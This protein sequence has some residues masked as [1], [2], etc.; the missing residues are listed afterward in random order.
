MGT[1]QVGGGRLNRLGRVVL[2]AKNTARKSARGPVDGLLGPLAATTLL[3]GVLLLWAR[4]YEQSCVALASPGLVYFAVFWGLLQ[5]RLER[6]RFAIEYYLDG[7]SPWRRRLRRSW[8]SAVICIIAAL[9][10]AVFLA[11]FAALGR[12]TDWLFFTGAA[13]LAPLLFN[14]VSVWPGRHFRGA[15][16]GGVLAAPAGVLTSRVAGHVLLALVVI[17]FV[18]FN[19]STIP[20]P[21]I[22]YPDFPELTVEA[23]VVRVGSDCAVVEE[24]LR[25][26]AAFDGAGWFFM[27]SAERWMTEEIM[28]IFWAAFFLSAALA[29]TGFVRGLEGAML[30]TGCVEPRARAD[31]ARD[32]GAETSTSRWAGRIRRVTLLLVPLTVLT[33]VAHHVLQQRAVERWSAELRTDDRT[34][35]RRVIEVSVDNA[36]APAYA[37]IPEFADRHVS[38]GGFL[39]QIG[40]VFGEDRSPAAELSRMVGSAREVAVKDVHRT[41]REND[42]ARLAH[43]FNRDVAALPPG[44]RSA[45]EWV[46]EPVLGRA[47][48]GL[49]KAVGTDPSGVLGEMQRAAKTADIVTR[50]WNRLGWIVASGVGSDL[51]GKALRQWATEVL[52]QE[53][54]LARDD[55]WRAIETATRGNTHGARR[56]PVQAR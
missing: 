45:Y 28:L 48:S 6:R 56:S 3:L 36:F 2:Q 7:N 53:R 26:A 8:L 20:A 38:F 24:G 34:E 50:G 55:L 21:A 18:Y 41:L 9:P 43:L 35:T 16:S 1:R 40:S 51:Y 23:F 42:L 32:C 31:G 15:A 37:A 14:C 10:L 39:D 44:L 29:M 4:T 22:I 54:A 5:Y 49:M 52:D 47:R 27:T 19:S 11:G 46:L 30:V 17:A 25:V 33:G 12:A 13:V